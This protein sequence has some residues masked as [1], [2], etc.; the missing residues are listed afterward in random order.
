MFRQ[1]EDKLHQQTEVRKLTTGLLFVH[2]QR[3]DRAPRR[4]SAE[5]FKGGAI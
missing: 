5:E 3:A 2:L 1:Y 4:D